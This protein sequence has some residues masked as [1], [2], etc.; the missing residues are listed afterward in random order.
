[1]MAEQVSGRSWEDLM[2]ERLFEKLEMAS[3]G[4]GPP[5]LPSAVDQPWGHRANKTGDVKAVHDDNPAVMGPASNAHM[6]LSDWAKFASLHLRGAQGKAR[7]LKP[8]TFRALHTPPRGETYAG[9]WIVGERS[10]AGGKTLMHS[11]SNTS[12]YASIW[13]AP[14]RDTVYLAATNQGGDAGETAANE[15]I[16]ALIRYHA[17]AANR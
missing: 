10:W 7:L 2:R 9:G 6:T 13:I 17:F 8:A 14:A 1:L 15:A 16:E 4:F 12:W 5:G 11:G 3:A